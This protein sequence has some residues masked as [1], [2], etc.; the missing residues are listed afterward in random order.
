LCVFCFARIQRQKFKPVHKAQ[1]L[2]LGRLIG[3]FSTYGQWA[4]TTRPE[5]TAL[6]TFKEVKNFHNIKLD[7]TEDF[8]ILMTTPNYKLWLPL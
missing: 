8:Y 7:L 1:N 5:K 3:T 2:P 4:G 6:R